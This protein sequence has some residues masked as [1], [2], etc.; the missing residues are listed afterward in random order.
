MNEILS[1][2][3]I[4]NKSNNFILPLRGQYM[5]PC[6]VYVKQPEYYYAT[7]L[8]IVSDNGM[9]SFYFRNKSL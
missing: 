8:Q 6:D 4:N 7:V 3:N 9:S 1:L 5:T 2:N